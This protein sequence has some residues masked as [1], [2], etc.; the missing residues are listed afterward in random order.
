MIS[1]P[2]R[3][4]DAASQDLT[5]RVALFLQQLRLTSYSRLVLEA[6]GGVVTL[7]GLVP[8]FH[9]RQR[10]LAATRQVA[11]VRQVIDRLEVAESEAVFA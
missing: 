8:T 2:V 10:I 5:Q 7:A 3:S 1:V 6:R 11:G 4:T 9:Q